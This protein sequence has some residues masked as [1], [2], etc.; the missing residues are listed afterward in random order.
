M[1]SFLC[2]G[3]YLWETTSSFWSWQCPSTIRKGFS[4]LEDALA[5]DLGIEPLL[6][7]AS[8]FDVNSVF[9]EFLSILISVFGELCPSRGMDG[10]LWL[11]SSHLDAGL[12]LL[13]RS[14]R[15]PFLSRESRVVESSPRWNA[16]SRL[17]VLELAELPLVSIFR[18]P[19]EHCSWVLCL[20]ASLVSLFVSWISWALD[21]PVFESL[22]TS[23]FSSSVLVLLKPLP[24]TFS[25]WFL[26]P[27]LWVSWPGFEDSLAV[28]SLLVFE[29]S[30]VRAKLLSLLPELVLANPL[31]EYICEPV[32]ADVALD[33]EYLSKY[34]DQAVPDTLLP[35]LYLEI[36]DVSS[37][38]SHWISLS[39][40][41]GGFRGLVTSFCW[42]IPTSARL[43]LR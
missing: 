15:L 26:L 43:F 31:D 1:E 30:L 2:E 4:I 17:K 6:S 10:L 36:L 38:R 5:S 25:L 24:E 19:Q 20:L 33:D 21:E 35:P 7:C 42:M 40:F 3:S 9:E 41:S 16:R 37:T 8:G 12:C 11:Y 39:V 28:D 14:S 27:T 13:L 29:T 34:V 23:E 32:P 22:D 18:A